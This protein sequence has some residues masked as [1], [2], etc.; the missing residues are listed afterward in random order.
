MIIPQY[1]ETRPLELSDKPLFDRLFKDDPPEIS[2]LTFTN[3]FSWASA[4]KF[5]VSSSRDTVLVIDTAHGAP[6]AFFPLGGREGP[7]AA[8]SLVREACM[9]LMRVPERYAR[10]LRHDPGISIQEDRDNADY[11]Y[12]SDELI[13]LAGRKFDGKRQFIR[14]FK[15]ANPDYEYLPIS[16]RIVDDIL[17]FQDTWC[18]A[19]DCEKIKSLQDE[20][21]AVKIMLEYYDAFNLKGGVIRLRGK[22]CA[23]CIG[24]ALNPQTMVI[25]VLKGSLEIPGITQTVFNEFLKREVQGS[26]LVN[27]EQDL[28]VAG[29]RNA[30]TS[31]H[32]NSLVMKYSIMA[33][34]VRAGTN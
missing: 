15:A 17:R 34:G 25:H 16:A 26:V 18:M 19:K 33:A 10:M 1:P 5:A 32:P 29:L 27:M 21:C 13:A 22:I 28:G 24:E 7:D 31:Y 9:S 12:R 4:Y 30:K 6:R 23:V 2:E 3:L 11:V 20:S 8:R 14:N